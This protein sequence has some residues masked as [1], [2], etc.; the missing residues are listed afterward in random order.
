VRNPS[1]KTGT[2]KA[3]NSLAR[4]FVGGDATALEVATKEAA[5]LR[6]TDEQESASY[7]IKTMERQAE[8]G[9]GYAKAER[10]RLKGLLKGVSGE[11]VISAADQPLPV[12]RIP[13]SELWLDFAREMSQL[14][15]KPSLRSGGTSWACLPKQSKPKLGRSLS[16][17]HQRTRRRRKHC[18][19]W[20]VFAHLSSNLIHWLY[21]GNRDHLLL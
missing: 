6:N 7:Y 17:R 10:A 16:R 1:Q 19:T 8:K 4:K 18:L 21:L 3:F 12:C 13:V 11:T 2:I 5:V 9:E 15:R 20:Y 14:N